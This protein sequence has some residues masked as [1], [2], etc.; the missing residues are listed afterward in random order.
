MKANFISA[1]VRYEYDFFKAENS[2]E[3]VTEIKV[4]E[5]TIVKITSDVNQGYAGH[6][7]GWNGDTVMRYWDGDV[8]NS[9]DNEVIK[10][11]KEL[12]NY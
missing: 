7:Y 3:E 5:Q 4:D 2:L 11:I 12:L 9:H 10:K 8:R 1:N 6:L